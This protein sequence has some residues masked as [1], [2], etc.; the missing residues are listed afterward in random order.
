MSFSYNVF[1]I[2]KNYNQKKIMSN[3]TTTGFEPV[4]PKITDF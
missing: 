2:R 1:V 4:H 3:S